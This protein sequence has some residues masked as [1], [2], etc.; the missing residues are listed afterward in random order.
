MQIISSIPG[1][2]LGPSKVLIVL[3][4]EQVSHYSFL[5]AGP[6]ESYL[7]YED[8][9][10]VERDGQRLA[11]PGG[12]LTTL[13]ERL[14]RFTTQPSRLPFTGGFVGYFGYDLAR[15]LERLPELSP[16]HLGLPVAML[17]RFDNLLVFDHVRQRVVAV[18]NEIDGEVS[19]HRYCVL[20]F[21]HHVSHPK[22]VVMA[23]LT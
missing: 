15:M 17:S 2:L 1:Y 11:M 12:P 16:D 9:L 14:G 6:T 19:H 23:I 3:G 8:R 21:S 10:E 4:G 5:G 13:R 18:A 22:V 7:L 20:R